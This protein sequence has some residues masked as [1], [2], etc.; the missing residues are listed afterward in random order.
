MIRGIN[1]IQGKL[2]ELLTSWIIRH[3]LC[4]AHAHFTE[5]AL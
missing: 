3:E 4:S 1:S 5:D 2:A